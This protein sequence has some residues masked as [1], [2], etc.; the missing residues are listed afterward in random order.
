[1]PGHEHTPKVVM[2]N[3]DMEP[4]IARSDTFDIQH[5]D[6]DLDVTQYN[7]QQI[8]AHTGILL[9]IIENGADEVR[10]DLVDLT[11]DSVFIDGAPTAFEHI[12][13]EL[14]IPAPSG[15]FSAGASHL[16]DVHYSGHPH[17]DSYWGGVYFA[18]GYVYHLGIGLTSIP[19]N[20]GKVWHPCFD[21][22]V[23]RATY[24]WNVKSTG[25]YR[26]H[27]QGASQTSPSLTTPSQEASLSSTPSQLTKP[28]L[29]FL[30]TLT[31]T[32]Y[33]PASTA[34]SR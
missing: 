9:N 5:F 32:T 11:V 23:E 21:N 14:K 27:L 2:Q 18:S 30:T 29:P 7:L 26:A 6:V 10:F 13:S 22:F 33:T 20:F 17:A 15:T 25:G 12:D 4:S 31:A 1:M 19:P 24:T 3:Y 28:L 16:I 8:T 34:T